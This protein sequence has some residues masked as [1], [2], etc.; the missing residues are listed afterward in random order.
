MAFER[1][2]AAPMR[3]DLALDPIPVAL[4]GHVFVEGDPDQPAGGA[5]VEV[6]VPPGLATTT[7]AAGEFRLIALP[8]AAVLTIRVTHAGDASQHSFRPDFTQ[9]I[10]RAVFATA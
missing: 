2:A 9:R 8:V 5:D 6:I 10:N 7:D 3:I 4:E 1:I